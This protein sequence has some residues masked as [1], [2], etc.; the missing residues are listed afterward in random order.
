[1]RAVTNR[2]Y[3]NSCLQLIIVVSLVAGCSQPEPKSPTRQS[4]PSLAIDSSAQHYDVVPAESLLVVKVYRDGALARL[5]H[6][7]VVSSTDLHGT[8]FL[9]DPVGES[10]VEVRLPL[11]TLDVDLTDRRTDAGPDFVG[12]VDADDI[13]GTRGNMLGTQQL[14]VAVWPQ[15]VLRSREIEGSLPD[16]MLRAELSVK[17]GAYPLSVPVRIEHIAGQI[18]ASGHFSIKQT[19]LGLE[20]FSVMMGALQVRDQL[21]IEFRL[22]A[23][24]AVR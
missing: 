21:D 22:V 24:P 16:V 9:A 2:F 8:I 20:P 5:G 1:M 6:N 15:I 18:V 11:T 13:A 12:E 4:F 23:A 17:S 10:A 19:E 14:D 3:L 7:H